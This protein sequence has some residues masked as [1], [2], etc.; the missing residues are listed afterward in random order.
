MTNISKSI[1]QGFTLIELLIVMSILIILVGILVP[2]FRGYQNEAWIVKAES[3]INTLQLVVESF[4]AKKTFYPGK[5]SDVLKTTPGIISRLPR[6]PFKT[7]GENYGYKI[8]EKN[9]GKEN[10]YIIYSRGPN[11]KIEWEWDSMQG[12][13][14][15]EPESDDIIFTNAILE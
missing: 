10:F 5:L 12:I 3:E 11:R 6:D 13:I 15:L 2:S 14:T 8:I 7:V 4:F 1:K 9:S